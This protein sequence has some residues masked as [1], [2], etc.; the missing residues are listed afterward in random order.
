M[1]M[2][3]GLYRKHLPELVRS[4]E[5]PEAALNASVRRVLAAKNMLGLF[6][7]P[8][9]RIDEKRE[10]SRSMPEEPRACA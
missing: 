2:Q 3:S 9:R 7:N 1:S 8:F 10:Q 4:G 5:V 6:E